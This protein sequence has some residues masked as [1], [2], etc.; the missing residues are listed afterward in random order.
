M[1]RDQ[2]IYLIT[3]VREQRRINCSVKSPETGIPNDSVK[4]KYDKS[5]GGGGR[6]RQSQRILGL[7]DLI[8]NV[9]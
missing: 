8:M 1:P 7:T 6:R 5:K 3:T 2:E 4:P 9:N